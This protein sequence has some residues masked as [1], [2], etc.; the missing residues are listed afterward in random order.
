[1]RLAQSGNAAG[2]ETELQRGIDPISYEAGGD[3]IKRD[4]ERN[5]FIEALQLPV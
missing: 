3:K 2:Q 1:M 4:E 5:D